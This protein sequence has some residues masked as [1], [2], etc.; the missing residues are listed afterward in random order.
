MKKFLQLFGLITGLLIFNSC[1]ESDP[2][3][4]YGWDDPNDISGPR[5]LKKVVTNGVDE[6]LYELNQGKLFQVKRN[7][8]DGN[9]A[10]EQQTIYVF[11]LGNRISKIEVNG[12][13]PGTTTS[14]R[15]DLTPNYNQTSGKIVSLMSDFYT[16]TT[17]KKHAITTYVYDA[18]GKLAGALTKTA[19]IDPS[20]PTNYIYPD[21]RKDYLKFD[22]NNVT[23]IESID[24]V[25]NVTTGVI[26]S[27]ESKKYEFSNYDWRMNPYTGISDN[28]L[29]IMATLFPEMYAHFSDNNAAKLKF[30]K[31]TDPVVETNFTYKYDTHN[32]I[33]SNGFQKFL[34]QSKP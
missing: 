21:Y 19:T 9:T 22:G 28:Y 24:E 10:V 33:T 6:E 13:Y 2:A 15:F 7:K 1:S 4:V 12:T 3:N 23:E 20:S 8:Y 26:E 18:D 17:H 25:V 16:G 29:M 27:S 11:Y 5:I 34:Y 14:G 30:T 32:Y 31:G